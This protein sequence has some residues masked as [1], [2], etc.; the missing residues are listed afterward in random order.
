MRSLVERTIFCFIGLISFRTWFV[1]G[2]PILYEVQGG[3]MATT[4]LGKH[5]D[6]TCA[7]CKFTF[8]YDFQDS[9]DLHAVCPNCG[10]KVDVASPP[11]MLAGDRVLID[12]TAFQVRRPRRWEVVA[13]QRFEAVGDVSGAPSLTVKRVVGL[14]GE[15]IEIID[16][17]VYANGQIQRKS[18]GHQRAMRVL[19]HDDDFAGPAP[20][21]RPQEAGSNWSRQPSGLAHAESTGEDIGWIVYNHTAAAA[22][23]RTFDGVT[24][25]NFYNRGRLQRNETIHPM[26]DLAMSFRIV[27]I[28]GRGLFWLR[29]TD[30]HDEF[31]VEVQPGDGKFTIARNRELLAERS[32]DLHGS[33]RGQTIEISLIDR[34]FLFA[35]NSRTMATV[36]ID[37]PLPKE[38]V[39]Q[40]LAIGVRGLGM[41][42]DHLRVYRDLFYTAGPL[43][44]PAGPM[45]V[46]LGA[47]EYF[48]LGDNSPISQDSRT[49]SENR[50][51]AHTSLV[52][53]PFVVVYPASGIS[54]A[55]LHFQVPDLARIRYIR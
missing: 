15:K 39:P 36:N 23:S 17:D 13:F 45:P 34:Q 7:N 31:M 29:A 16:G 47:N 14:P 18:F 54:L 44:S 43:G 51:V 35:V 1:D 49:W 28:H 52:G 19:V 20:R 53:R 21:W 37:S 38:S 50:L 3:S 8:A 12:R 42:V 9:E 5:F 22:A 25:F 55:G 32:G 46:L 11:L 6:T 40:P 48:V 30:G 26:A 41:V 27:E 10:A 2:F 33:L 4:L 24:D